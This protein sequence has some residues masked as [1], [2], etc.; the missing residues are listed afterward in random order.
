MIEMLV[1][2][3]IIIIMFARFI[4]WAKIGTII[5]VIYAYDIM[6]NELYLGG[7]GEEHQ[8]KLEVYLRF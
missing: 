8:Y 5:N 3:D 1:M 6:N 7:Q 2:N 4:R